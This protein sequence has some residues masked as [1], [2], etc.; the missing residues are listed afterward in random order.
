MFAVRSRRLGL[1]VDGMNAADA[2]RLVE[3]LS[4]IYWHVRPPEIVRFVR[5]TDPRL[6]LAAFTAMTEAAPDAARD[7][8]HPWLALETPAEIAALAAAAVSRLAEAGP[9]V[10]VL[11]DVGRFLAG[12]RGGRWGQFLQIC[13]ASSDAGMALVALSSD[14]SNPD[15]QRI[16]EKFHRLAGPTPNR[17]D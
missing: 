1:W 3:I 4:G 14:S 9:T 12:T 11:F 8:Q 17:T 15:A 2:D 10:L 6:V 5:L 16:R 7:S 13:Q